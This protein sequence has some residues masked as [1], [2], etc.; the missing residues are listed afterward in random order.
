MK[1]INLC[2]PLNT[3]CLSLSG[4]SSLF[5]ELQ[6]GLGGAGDICTPAVSL[7]LW[8][9][10][11]RMMVAV[12]WVC[13]G[14]TPVKSEGSRSWI[15]EVLQCSVGLPPREEESR[16]QGWAG[17]GQTPC[18][19]HPHQAGGGSRAGPAHQGVPTGHDGQRPPCLAMG[20]GA[21]ESEN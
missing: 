5:L 1:S 8:G 21:Q 12:R 6:Q 20:S 15:R 13:W 17:G 3:A 11:A 9:D 16:Q 4:I 18:S 2:K 10:V 19:C 14:V 7:G